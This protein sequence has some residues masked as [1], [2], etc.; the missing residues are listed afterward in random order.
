MERVGGALAMREY[1]DGDEQL[2][3]G[4][5][6][7]PV[8]SAVGETGAVIVSCG[9][10]SYFDFVYRRSVDWIDSRALSHLPCLFL[11]RSREELNS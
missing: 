11:S 5:V 2:I 4:S 9:R 6:P 10:E 8:L 1:F 7:L 3:A